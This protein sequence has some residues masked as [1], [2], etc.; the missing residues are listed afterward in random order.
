M[1][2][3]RDSI[4][5]QTREREKEKINQQNISYNFEQTINE[6]NISKARVSAE[7]SNLETEMLAFENI[8]NLR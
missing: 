7:I 8:N 5:S 1:I 2:S 6:L 4:H 3:E